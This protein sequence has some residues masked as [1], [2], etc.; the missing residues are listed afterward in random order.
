MRKKF[1]I[2]TDRIGRGDDELGATLMANVL[3]YLAKAGSA[4]TDIILLNDGVRLACKGSAVLDSLKALAG[5]GTVIRSC[6]TCLRRFDLVDSLAVGEIGTM[7]GTVELLTAD[8]GVV[9]IA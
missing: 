7:P 2:V 4:P 1:L 3:G 9:T 5:R 8:E 6:I